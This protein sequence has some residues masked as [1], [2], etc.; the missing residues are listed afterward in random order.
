MKIT[1]FF[2]GALLN[3]IWAMSYPL[4]KQLLSELSVSE[5]TAWRLVPSAILL[6]LTL[7]KAHLSKKIEWLDLL[8][9]T[10]MG[11]VGCLAAMGL[12]FL[13]TQHTLSSNIALLVAL[14]PP[15][16]AVM[17]ALFA[18]ESITLRVIL[19]IMV[20]ISGVALVS[21]NLDQVELFNKE[22]LLGN[23]V[24][25]AADF[26]YAYYTLSGKLLS[27][28]G[29]GASV[30]TSLPMAIAA[31][32]WL[33]GM[34]LFSEPHVGRLGF[35][36]IHDLKTFGQVF[37]ISIVAT[38]GG[39]FA[40]NF[41]IIRL[42][43]RTLSLTLYLQPIFGGIFAKWIFKENLPALFWPGL[44]LVVSGVWL[45]EYPSRKTEFQKVQ[46]PP[47]GPGENAG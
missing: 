5:V 20:A 13:A 32:F 29:W 16:V 43:A 39:Y 17:A 22:Y 27:R 42:N 33:I 7:K 26:C 25:L 21:V 47:D 34:S 6:M 19:G 18:G 31:V 36:G 41:L 44:F 4:S 40:W 11:L 38:A 37:W 46:L 10:S 45:S 35:F 8:G 12:Q 23:C 3:A 9:I 2:L 14:E 15:I 24:M 30:L 28:R 1:W